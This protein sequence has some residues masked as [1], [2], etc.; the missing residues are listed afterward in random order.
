MIFDLQGR[1]V[2]RRHGCCDELDRW[3]RHLHHVWRH[4]QEDRRWCPGCSEIR[5]KFISIK[6]PY[7]LWFSKSCIEHLRLFEQHSCA[8]GYG[9]AFV[10]YPEALSQLPVS[11]LWS[12]L[13]FFMLFTL[14]LDSEVTS[15]CFFLDITSSSNDTHKD[16]IVDSNEWEVNSWSFCYFQF[17]LLETFL[18]CIQDEF[19][20]TRKYKSYMCVGMGIICFFLA[21][22]CVTPVCITELQI[23][24]TYN[25]FWRL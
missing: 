10:A 7:Y 8:A 19:P 18:T 13:F 24:D 17:A 20:S 22:P 12:V 23:N 4:G 15:R 11:Q 3:L 25:V 2:D 6:P 14:G 5:Y 9:L 21:L 1:Y 16:L